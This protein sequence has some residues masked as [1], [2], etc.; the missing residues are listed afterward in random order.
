MG[1]YLGVDLGGSKTHI[2]IANEKGVAVGFGE[3]GGGNHQ[4]VGYDGMYTALQTALADALKSATLKAAQIRAAGF[5]IAGYDWPSEKGMMTGVIDRLG[6]GVPYELVNDTIP[7][8]VAGAEEGWGV[9]VVSGTGC[10][11]RGW[12]REHQREGRVTG[13]GIMMGEA[14][15]GT[16]LAYRAMQLVGFEWM[17]RGPKTA[18]TQVF[19]NATGAKDMEDLLEGYTEGRYQAKAEVAP[20]I[21]EVA[22][23]GDMVAQD[24]IRWAGQELGEMAISVIHQLDFEQLEFD[25]VLS[26]SMFEGGP[27]LVDPMRETIQKVAPG[28]RMVRLDVPPVVGA[29]L[30]GMEKDGIKSNPALRK[31]LADS[32]QVVMQAGNA[33]QL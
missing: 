13:Y 2:V 18:L 3:S 21:F 6:L 22:R 10:N 7:G 15:G 23:Q 17:Q 20:F 8:L 25:V 32:V 31:S 4:S 5:G 19:I 29:V 14:A 26:G 30:I 27:A 24:L 16:E 1:Y 11:C 33:Q 28:A 12:D 9:G